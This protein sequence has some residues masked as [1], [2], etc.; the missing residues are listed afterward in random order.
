[1]NGL[2]RR[3]FLP[4]KTLFH[5]PIWS[6]PYENVQIEMATKRLIKEL[7][8]FR[9]ETKSKATDSASSAVSRLEPVSDEDLLHLVATLKGP[10]GTGYEGIPPY[11]SDH[12]EPQTNQ[13]Q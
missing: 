4:T 11:P 7:D 2:R 8:A 1:M 12:L 10:E 9:R 3:T 6:R 13:S 5:D